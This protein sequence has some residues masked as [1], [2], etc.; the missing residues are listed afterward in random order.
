VEAFKIP[1]YI[2]MAIIFAIE[3]VVDVM[4]LTNSYNIARWFVSTALVG[5]FGRKRLNT[6]TI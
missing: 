4:Y 1:C 5:L 3:I 6:A 2:L